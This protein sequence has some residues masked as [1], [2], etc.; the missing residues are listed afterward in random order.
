[1]HLLNVCRTHSLSP[2]QVSSVVV[3][4]HHVVIEKNHCVARIGTGERLPDDHITWL[5]F[6]RRYLV[7]TIERHVVQIKV[8]PSQPPAIRPFEVREVNATQ[9]V[10]IPEKRVAVGNP[11]FKATA[12][13]MRYRAKLS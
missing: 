9:M 5:R 13:Q 7:E 11:M 2:A 10:S 6:A 4:K 12:K 1:M 3:V 8:L